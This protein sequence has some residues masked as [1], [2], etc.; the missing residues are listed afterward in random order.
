MKDDPKDHLE[1][2]VDKFTFRFPRT[3]HYS[4]AGVWIIGT[5]AREG[6]FILTEQMRPDTTRLVPRSRAPLARRAGNIRTTSL[7][8]HNP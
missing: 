7:G 3:L 1:V 8:G 4:D 5:V 6:A 2:I